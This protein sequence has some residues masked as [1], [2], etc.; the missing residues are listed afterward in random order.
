MSCLLK[1]SLYFI[2][3]LFCLITTANADTIDDLLR[4]PNDPS[5]GDP[6]AK[7]TVVEFFDYQCS[8]CRNM[9]ATL[10]YLMPRNPD[11]HFVFKDYPIRGQVSDLAARIA[12][13]ANIQHKYMVINHQLLTSDQPLTPTLITDIAENVPGIDMGKLQK[14]AY[15]YQV[16]T[17]IKATRALANTLQIEGTPIFYIARTSETNMNKVKVVLGSMSQN[18]MQEVIDTVMKGEAA[19]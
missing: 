15:G 12:L 19:V 5:V 11:V 6:K 3:G 17:Q 10:A 1:S 2:F 18:E 9:A 8:H 13:A 4:N 16:V 14:D 7:V